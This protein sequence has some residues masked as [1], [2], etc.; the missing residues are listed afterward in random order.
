MLGV[1]FSGFWLYSHS[2]V[3]SSGYIVGKKLLVPYGNL[4]LLFWVLLSRLWP[5]IQQGL[6]NRSQQI[7]VAVQ[8]F[9]SREDA[10]ILKYKE[11]KEKL[12]HVDGETT[13][14]VENAKAAAQREAVLTVEKAEHRA[15]RIRSDAKH[16]ANHESLKVQQEVQR[17]MI[18]RAFGQAETLLSEQMTE[19]DET[20]L[21]QE[22]LKKLG[23]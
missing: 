4:G 9:E 18:E 11:I 3:G 5:G 10:I 23:A 21:Q 16:L 22:F 20:A 6:V 14:I 15:G 7:S 17:L 19:D 13:E 8:D 2:P 12:A 1:L